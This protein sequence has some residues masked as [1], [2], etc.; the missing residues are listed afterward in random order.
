[1]SLHA[2]H[3]HYDDR[4]NALRSRILANTYTKADC[5]A[6]LIMIEDILEQRVF[7]Q[8]SPSSAHELLHTLYAEREPQHVAHMDVWIDD[9]IAALA[10]DRAGERFRILKHL[11][12]D[13]PVLV[14]YVPVALSETSFAA[15]AGW[16]RTEIVHDV[17]LDIR[18]DA[19]AVGGCLFAWNG[20][21]HDFSF[22]YFLAK[23]EHEY[24]MLVSAARP[25]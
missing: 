12:A 3:A 22:S 1:M 5:E 23:H 16:C 6:R 20:V 15:I 21:L 24:H 25:V 14:L 17:L 13:V 8:G 2:K 10:V 11:L 19:R 18:I 7:V 9:I 4:Y